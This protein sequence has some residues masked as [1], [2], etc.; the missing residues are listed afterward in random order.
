MSADGKALVCETRELSNSGQLKLELTGFGYHGKRDGKHYAILKRSGE[1]LKLAWVDSRATE[2]D[3]SQGGKQIVYTA[4][5]PQ[6][7]GK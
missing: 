6:S 4:V 5:R 1:K 7:N 3:S 2:I